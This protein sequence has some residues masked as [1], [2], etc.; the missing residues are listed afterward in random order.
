V[1][2]QV[3]LKQ[4]DTAPKAIGDLNADVSGATVRFRL[5]KLN[6][7]AVLDKV[8]TATDAPNGIVEYQ[9]VTGDTAVLLPG[10]YR[11]EFVVTF[12]GGLIERF[13]QRSYI[14]VHVKAATPVAV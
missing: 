10:D 11:G 14:E 5:M 2:N 6:G 12:A 1:A 7:T 9:W 8:A 13:P 4:G 3:Y